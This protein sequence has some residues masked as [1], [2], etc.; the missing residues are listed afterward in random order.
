M[1][2]RMRTD[3]LPCGRPWQSQQPGS[4]NQDLSSCGS[5]RAAGASDDCGGVPR[6][7]VACI[8][9]HPSVNG[10]PSHGAGSPGAFLTKKMRMIFAAPDCEEPTGG[11]LQ[12]IGRC[13]AGSLVCCI[14]GCQLAGTVLR[15]NAYNPLIPVGTPVVAPADWQSAKQQT[16]LSAL[17][18]RSF[19]LG[20]SSRCASARGRW[21]D[22]RP[23]RP[24]R[25]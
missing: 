6:F 14:A 3:V 21:L 8:V 11:S 9:A 20:S 22:N 10:R 24:N 17:R 19:S 25:V 7:L 13:S 16:R 1:R 23:L 2:I 4:S 15:S 18:A 5:F 12:R